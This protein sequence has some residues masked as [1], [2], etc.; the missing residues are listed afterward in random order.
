MPASPATFVLV[1]EMASALASQQVEMAVDS[2]SGRNCS[3][4]LPV[5]LFLPMP[6]YYTAGGIAFSLQQASGLMSGKCGSAG[7]HLYL[8]AKVVNHNLCIAS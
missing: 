3:S 1:V 8:L 2:C 5:L 6:D 7:K 4:T